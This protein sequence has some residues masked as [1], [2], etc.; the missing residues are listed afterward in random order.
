M[1]KLIDKLIQEGYLETPRIIEAFEKIQRKDFLINFAKNR[2]DENEPI[3]IGFGQTISQPSTIAFMFELLQPKD[4]DRVLDIGSGSGYTTALFSQLVGEEGKVFGIEIIEELK[5]FGEE[6]VRKNYNFVGRG[7]AN[8]R[9]ADGSL[10]LESEAPF[11]II[12]VAAAA[13]E[14]PQELL[15]QLAVGGK[16]VVPVGEYC[17]EIYLYTKDED[18]KISKEKYPGFSFVPLINKN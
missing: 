11:D 2:E 10:G 8:F 1:N 5:E 17:H 18:G 9:I 16:M 4:G 14:A 7:V 12:H 3:S 15:D 13:L 6:N